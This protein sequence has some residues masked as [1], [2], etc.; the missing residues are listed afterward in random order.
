[1]I[2]K[3]QKKEVIKD[4]TDKLSKQKAVIFFDYSGLK[5]NK[6]QEL[7]RNLRDQ[8]IDCQ[9]NKKTLIS[10]SLEKSGFKGVGTKDLPGQ[11]ALVLGYNDEVLPAK[12]LYDFSKTNKEIKIL[13][14]FIQGEYLDNLSIE[15]LAKLPSRQELLSKAIGSMLSPISNLA[16]VFNGNLI[17]LT[18]ILKNL[19]SEV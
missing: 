13:S 9:A 11:V 2:S 17:K 3:E 8:E 10:L 5:V 16:Y 7:R 4:L 18:N 14:G 6:F 19:K 12:I 1:M 15:N